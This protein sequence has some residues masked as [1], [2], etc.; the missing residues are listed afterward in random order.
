MGALEADALSDVMQRSAAPTPAPDDPAEA[1]DPLR[2]ISMRRL[3]RQGLGAL[4]AADPGFM[5]A[6]GQ[7]LGPGPE[8]QSL[9]EL[10]AGGAE[11]E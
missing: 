2:S 1:A 10:L 8:L 7:Q 6:A 9:Q 3:L 5:A 11:H 4:A